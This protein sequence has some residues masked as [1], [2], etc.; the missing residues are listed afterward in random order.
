MLDS[1]VSTQLHTDHSTLACRC[2]TYPPVR[3]P[4]SNTPFHWSL[5]G[6]GPEGIGQAMKGSSTRHLLCS[7]IFLTTNVDRTRR[8]QRWISSCHLAVCVNQVDKESGLSTIC[9]K[10]RCG[11]NVAT[12]I[13]ISKWVICRLCWI[14]L[15]LPLRKE[16]GSVASVNRENLHASQPNWAGDLE[17]WADSPIQAMSRSIGRCQIETG[18][19]GNNATIL[20]PRFVF[21]LLPNRIGRIG[22]LPCILPCW[23]DE[24]AE[25]SRQSQRNYARSKKKKITIKIQVHQLWPEWL[26]EWF[27]TSLADGVRM[28]ALNHRWKRRMGFGA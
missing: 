2:T 28:L 25:S 15:Q 6:D 14:D 23:R 18:S 16:S 24:E 11:F 22:I 9:S 19:P 20:P 4:I 5:G 3:R 8:L 10:R 21:K 13:M 26:P 12:A 1:I 17:R 7:S 27:T